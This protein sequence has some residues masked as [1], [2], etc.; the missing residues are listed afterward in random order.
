MNIYIYIYIHITHTSNNPY[1][2]LLLPGA[3][4]PRVAA[5]GALLSLYMSVLFINITSYYIIVYY[6][7]FSSYVINC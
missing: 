3:R 2:S 7:L 4:L 5:A 6:C 1:E